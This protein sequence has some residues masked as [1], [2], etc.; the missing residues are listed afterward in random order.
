MK[1]LFTSVGF[2][3]VVTYMPYKHTPKPFKGS[4]FDVLWWF[5]VPIAIGGPGLVKG[6]RFRTDLPHAGLANV[7]STFINLHGFE[8]P[9]DYEPTLIEVVEWEI[10]KPKHN[11]DPK[12]YVVCMF[13]L[14]TPQSEVAI[15]QTSTFVVLQ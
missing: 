1:E 8:A 2:V 12:Q 5:Q 15:W 7:A 13:H 4:C 10:Y 9:H 11:T 14:R 6:A 3:L